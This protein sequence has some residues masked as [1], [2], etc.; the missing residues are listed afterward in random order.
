MKNAFLRKAIYDK[1]DEFKDDVLVE[2]EKII[3]SRDKMI[4]VKKCTQDEKKN[5]E[6]KQ[7]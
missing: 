6:E 3:D 1:L 7:Q 2:T 5:H 4:I